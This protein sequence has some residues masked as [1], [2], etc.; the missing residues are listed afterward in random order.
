MYQIPFESVHYFLYFL[1]NIEN[2]GHKKIQ[3]EIVHSEKNT[4]EE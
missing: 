3:I 1:K 2:N 4:I